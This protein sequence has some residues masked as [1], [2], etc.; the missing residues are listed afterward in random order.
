MLCSGQQPD[1]SF[2]R[3]APNYYTRGSIE[4]WDF[5]RDQQLNYH[6]GNAIK[7]ICRAGHKPGNSGAADLQK[8]IHYLQNEFQHHVDA[9]SNGIQSSVR[10][11]EWH[12]FAGDASEFDR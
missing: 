12:G 6:L 11:T 5:I 4:V 10:R 3:V 9:A 2:E 1:E 8:A 7:Y